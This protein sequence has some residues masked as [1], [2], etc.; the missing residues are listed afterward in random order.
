MRLLILLLAIIHLEFAWGQDAEK[1]QISTLLSSQSQAWNQ[2]DLEGFMAGYW[3]NDSLCFIGKS[4]VTYGWSHTLSNYKKGYPDKTAMGK[5]QFTILHVQ[6]L[7][8]QYAQVIGKWYLTRTIGDLSG[9]FTL[10]LK[11]MGGQWLIVSDHSS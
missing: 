8:S 9:H 5:L 10:L 7:S 11:K 4:G 3:K 6:L 1:L 2:G